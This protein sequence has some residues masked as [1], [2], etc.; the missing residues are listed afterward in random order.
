MA[1]CCD[2]YD[3]S[4]FSSIYTGSGKCSNC[5]GT[6]QVDVIV[7]PFEGMINTLLDYDP[8]EKE[9]CEECDGTGDC[10]TCGGTGKE[11]D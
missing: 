1:K 8:P 10:Q 7:L 5:K 11:D 2:C 4:I 9:D 6:G 3:S